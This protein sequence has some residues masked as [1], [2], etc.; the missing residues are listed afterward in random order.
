V[1]GKQKMRERKREK[2]ER[3]KREKERKERKRERE[4][5]EKGDSSKCLLKERSAKRPKF[6]REALVKGNCNKK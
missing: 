6:P 4:R 3:E 5:E 2:R 1:N